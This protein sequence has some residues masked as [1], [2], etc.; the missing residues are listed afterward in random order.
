MIDKSKDKKYKF[1]IKRHFNKKA[2]DH[3][4][5]DFIPNCLDQY[6]RAPFDHIIAKYCKRIDGKK[7]LDYCC[8]LE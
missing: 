8:E 2:L 6:F 4:V 5:E 1:E 3:N 7:I